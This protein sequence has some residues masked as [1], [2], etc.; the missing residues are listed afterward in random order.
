MRTGFLKRHLA[1]F[2]TEIWNVI[3]EEVKEV[4]SQRMIGRK[5]VDVESPKG[6]DFSA[7]NTGTRKK[8]DN[9]SFTIRNSLPVLEICQSFEVSKDDIENIYRGHAVLEDLVSL[10]Q[11]AKDFAWA[12]NSLIYSGL[13]EHQIS[14]LVCG[15]ETL[16]APGSINDNIVEYTVK[17]TEKMVES[18]VGGSYTMLLSLDDYAKVLSHEGYPLVRKMLGVLGEG[19][20]ILPDA[21]ASDGQATII[22]TRGGDYKLHLGS[23][24]SIGY[25]G[26]TDTHVQLFLFESCT[27]EVITPEACT[28]IKF[29]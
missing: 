8:L 16:T 7:L 27:F 25:T 20:K 29:Q 1:P 12:E 15:A 2:D 14:G 28:L 18:Y 4:L 26:E 17:A 13:A 22:S 19:G 11:G 6:L 3:G 9:S 23:D 5:I 24:V 10:Q 21:Q